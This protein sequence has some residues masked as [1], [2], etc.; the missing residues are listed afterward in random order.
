MTLF[1]ITHLSIQPINSYSAATRTFKNMHTF[2]KVFFAEIVTMQEPIFL[3]Q[4]AYTDDFLLFILINPDALFSSA[5][6]FHQNHYHANAFIF[7]RIL[8]NCPNLLT[9]PLWYTA[10]TNG[11]LCEIL[12]SWETLLILLVR[13]Q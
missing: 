6:E 1:I 12:S 11:S 2:L 13:L 9:E 3:Y 7:V 10:L 4:K 5:D 8:P